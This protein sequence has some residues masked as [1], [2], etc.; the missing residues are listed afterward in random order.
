MKNL[1]AGFIALMALSLASISF[2]DEIHIPI[3]INIENFKAD[4]LARGLDLNDKDGFVENKGMSIIVYTYHTAS[5]EQM[6]LIKDMAFKN[7]RR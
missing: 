7:V 3:A 5:E 6:D 4:C 2:A 1:L